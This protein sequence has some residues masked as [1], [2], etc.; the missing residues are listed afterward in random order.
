MPDP[1]NTIGN[2][3]VYQFKGQIFKENQGKIPQKE[4]GFTG[5]TDQITPWET[6]SE[7]V[8]A[9]R[10]KDVKKIKSLY[11]KNS[12]SKVSSVFEG[13][14]S[15]SAL[16][17]LSQCG[18]VKVLMGFEYQNGYY[19]IIETENLGITSNYFVLEKGKYKLS[20]LADKNPASWNIALYWKYKPKEFMQPAKITFPD[21]IS[22]TDTRNMVF[23][24]TN[25]GNWII[26]FSDKVGEPVLAYAQDGGYRDNDNQWKQISF[27][28]KASNLISKGR[29]TLYAIES[30]YPIQVVNVGMQEKAK[31]IS[32]IVY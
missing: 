19:A 15:T 3:L 9:Y 18:E 23:D 29:Y 31:P 12:Q 1:A 27:P 17:T 26:V 28:F 5:K 21:S 25:Q 30:N 13:E 8:W 10:N 22:I 11:N 14:N 7:L 16:N 4:D 24:L 20:V 2:E 6:L 32:I